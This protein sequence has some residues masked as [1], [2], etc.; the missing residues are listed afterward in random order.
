MVHH[1]LYVDPGS[2]SYII[3]VIVAAILG[4]GFWIKT[5]WYRIKSFFTG[6]KT[7]LPEKKEEK[8]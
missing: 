3:Q 2:G 1:L 6:R 8:K 7:E 4:A 5:S